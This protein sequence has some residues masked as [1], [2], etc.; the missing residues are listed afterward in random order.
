MS[1]VAGEWGGGL[2]RVASGCG[3]G[4]EVGLWFGGGGAVSWVVD[5]FGP[6]SGRYLAR[7]DVL[8]DGASLGIILIWT[9][10]ERCRFFIVEEL[11]A[12]GRP[13]WG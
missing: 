9:S 12:C 13:N 2:S 6:M 8:F 4:T 5:G 1:D 11:S 3:G 10:S 7:K